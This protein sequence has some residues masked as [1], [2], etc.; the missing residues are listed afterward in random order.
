MPLNLIDGNSVGWIRFSPQTNVWMKS[1]KDGKTEEFEFTDPVLIDVE[2]T[3][4]G[5]LALGKGVRE[6][7]PWP[8]GDHRQCPKPD[9]GLEWKQG[10]RVRFF[11]KK[12]FG[13]DD[14]AR[15]M[16][17]NGVGLMQFVKALYA[18]AEPNFS[19]GVPVVKITGARQTRF[20]KGPTRIPEYS[21]EKYVSRPEG[22]DFVAHNVENVGR[23]QPTEVSDDYVPG[24][25]ADEANEF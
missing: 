8:D 11:S 19:K 18:D 12:L 20:G 16:C 21:I 10:V 24:S 9:D 3:E 13:E 5:W 2:N 17:T 1:G 6:W 4:V 7:M 14:A 25:D 22:L 23:Q 15:E